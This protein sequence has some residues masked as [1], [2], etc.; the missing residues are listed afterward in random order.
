MSHRWLIS[1]LLSAAAV[2]ASETPTAPVPAGVDLARA[3]DLQVIDANAFIELVPWRKELP[4][5]FQIYVTTRDREA[6][7]LLRYHTGDIVQR[8]PTQFFKCKIR[9]FAFLAFIVC[10][11]DFLFFLSFLTLLFL[12]CNKVCKC[13]YEQ[14]RFL[15]GIIKKYRIIESNINFCML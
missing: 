4:G 5:V 2:G 6:M 1:F 10:C 15:H 13:C 8:L 3:H 9:C 11:F 14:F 7:P 12:I